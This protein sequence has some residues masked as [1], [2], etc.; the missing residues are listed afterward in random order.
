MHDLLE[1]KGDHLSWDNVFKEDN[2]Y[3]VS[4]HVLEEALSGVDLDDDVTAYTVQQT[5]TTPTHGSRHSL[6][7]VLHWVNSLRVLMLQ[8]TWTA[9]H[10]VKCP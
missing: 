4:M 9:L 10:G 1:D 2:G 7:M 6:R 5:R 8:A 3:K